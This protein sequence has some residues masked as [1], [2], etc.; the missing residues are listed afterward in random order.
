MVRLMIR[1]CGLVASLTL[2]LTAAQAEVLIA[3][4]GPLSGQNISLGEQVQRGAQ[5]T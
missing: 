4:A 1:R 5:M 2:S 3:V